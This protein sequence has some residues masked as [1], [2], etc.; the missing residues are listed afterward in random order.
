MTR[1]EARKHMMLWVYSL[2]D[3]PPRQV[4][5]ALTMAADALRPI[6]R[7]QVEK[8][9]RGE[10]KENKNTVIENVTCSKCKTVFQ[11]Y[12]GNYQF[13]P[14]CGKAMTDEAVQM[15]MERMEALYGE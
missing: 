7:K 6:S 4:T 11:A 14:R 10:W 8:V 5:E 13:C 15:V 3:M 12:Y 1:E 2:D 9:W